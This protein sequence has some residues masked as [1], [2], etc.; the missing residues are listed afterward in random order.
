MERSIEL[1][2][3][4]SNFKIRP[5]VLSMSAEKTRNANQPTV[6]RFCPKTIAVTQLAAA[7]PSGRPAVQFFGPQ[8]DP[9]VKIFGGG[10]SFPGLG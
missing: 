6:R 2:L 10:G 3:A 9:A 7:S 4:R 5:G 8:Q 1:S